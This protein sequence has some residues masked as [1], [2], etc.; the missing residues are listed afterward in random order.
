MRQLRRQ[1]EQGAAL[2]AA[3][4]NAKFAGSTFE[5]DH[6]DLQEHVD[7]VEKKI[8]LPALKIW[9]GMEMQCTGAGDSQRPFPV[10]NNG[11]KEATPAE[12]WEFVVRPD[13][14]KVYPGG[15]RGVLLDVFN[16]AHGAAQRDGGKRLDMPLQAAALEE[17]AQRNACS[18]AELVDSV[19][20]VALRSGKA[21][22]LSDDPL[23]RAIKKLKSESVADELNEKLKA[24]EQ[25]KEEL[26]RF[27]EKDLSD[28]EVARFAVGWGCPVMVTEAVMT[29]NGHEVPRDTWGKVREIDDDGDA[30][31]QFEGAD[32]PHRVSQ[33]DFDKLVLLQSEPL[34]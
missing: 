17:V 21:S 19:K 13:L 22:F 11:V 14:A 26:D 27:Q 10:P 31:V 12:E 20:T 30:L 29:D 18:P 4:M 1:L 15:R 5:G 2:D 7:G 23:Q 9:E 32:F 24:L 33:S 8:G 28:P 34:Y 6:G 3:Q 16:V 25:L